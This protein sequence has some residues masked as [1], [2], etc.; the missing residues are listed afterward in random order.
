MDNLFETI[1]Q[2]ERVNIELIE[3]TVGDSKP[4]ALL[5]NIK[6]PRF[7]YALWTTEKRKDYP[8]DPTPISFKLRDGE[9]SRPYDIVSTDDTNPLELGLLQ[10]LK[11]KFG[12]Y[13]FFALWLASGA[14]EYLLALEEVCIAYQI[15]HVFMH[16]Y[17]NWTDCG[18]ERHGAGYSRTKNFK[19]YDV[20]RD[21][22][23]L[24]QNHESENVNELMYLLRK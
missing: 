8:R 24:E 18:H 10:E 7:A 11:H 12:N 22:E 19:I 23:I 13:S 2:M 14:R 4:V 16:G 3:V 1:E 5:R 6:M 15:E 9:W 20:T 17:D 21:R